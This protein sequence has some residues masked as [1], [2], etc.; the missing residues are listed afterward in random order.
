MMLAIPTARV[1]SRTERVL[2]A[3]WASRVSALALTAAMLPSAAYA[4]EEQAAASE[5]A[6]APDNDAQIGEILVTARRVTER[7]QDIPASVSAVTGDQVARMSSLSDIQSMVSGVT[8]KSFGPNPTVGIRGYGN[9]TV[10]GSNA[11][12]T[13]GIFQDGVF[14]A[15]SLVGIAHRVDTSQVEVAKGPQSTLYAPRN[16]CLPVGRTACVDFGARRAG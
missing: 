11:N 10:A 16:R 3:R 14:V 13:V 9:R 8:F 4:A 1:G 15:P 2:A 12:S 5:P 6:V 7:L